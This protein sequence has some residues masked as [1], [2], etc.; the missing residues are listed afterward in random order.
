M[1]DLFEKPI[2]DMYIYEF[3]CLCPCVYAMCCVR[4]YVYGHMLCDG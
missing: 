2:S 4:D 3:I 1:F